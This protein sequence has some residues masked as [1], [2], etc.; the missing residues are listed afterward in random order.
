MSE[1]AFCLQVAI[2]GRSDGVKNFSRMLGCLDRFGKELF[3]GFNN[4]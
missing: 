4:D 3:F 1:D 2:D